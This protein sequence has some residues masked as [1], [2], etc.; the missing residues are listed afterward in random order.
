MAELTGRSLLPYV[1]AS[2]RRSGRRWKQ[3]SLAVGLL[4]VIVA[5]AGCSSVKQVGVDVEVTRAQYTE[6]WAF[7]VESGVLKCLNAAGR[8]KGEAIIDV[9]GATYAL[10][11]TAESAGHTPVDIIVAENPNFEEIKINYFKFTEIAEE[12]C[13]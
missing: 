11:E 9:A 2:S 13:Y 3:V 10:N 6:F 4:L 7:T 12:Q 8:R 5:L 1:G